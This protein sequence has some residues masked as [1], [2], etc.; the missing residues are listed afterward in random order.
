MSV[1]EGP[2]ETAGDVDE[3]KAC[4]DFGIDI[5]AAG[6]CGRHIEFLSRVSLAILLSATLKLDISVS[7]ISNISRSLFQ[8]L[9]SPTAH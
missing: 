5:S 9:L 4:L 6:S 2:G 1:S 7:F 8:L 3:L